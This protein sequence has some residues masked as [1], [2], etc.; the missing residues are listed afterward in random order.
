MALAA[1]WPRAYAPILGRTATWPP[2]RSRAASSAL[3]AGGRVLASSVDPVERQGLLVCAGPPGGS[4][5]A[6]SAAVLQAHAAR[7]RR[8]RRRPCRCARFGEPIAVALLPVAVMHLLL[9][10]PDGSCRLSRRAIVRSATSSA[11]PS[12]PR[13]LGPAAGLPLWPIAIEAVVAVARRRG[14]SQRR[15]VRSAG[16]ERQRMQWFGWAGAVAVEALLVALAL[17]VLL[18][19]PTRA[20]ARGPDGRSAPL[21]RGARHVQHRGASPP[22]STASSP[23]P[24]RSAGLT[25]VVAG[26]LPRSWSLVWAHTP[27]RSERSLLGLSMVS[28]AVA[29]LLYGPARQ[30]LAHVRQPPRL[31]RTRGTR[32][33]PAHLREPPFPRHPDGRAAPA[34][35]GVAEKDAGARQRRGLDGLQ[36]ASRALRLGARLQPDRFELKPDEERR[37]CPGRRDGHGLA[38]ASGCRPSLEGGRSRCSGWHPPRHSGQRARPHRRR[39]SR[40]AG[41]VHDRRRHDADRTGPPGRPGPPQ[42]RAG[43]GP[44]E[45][46][47]GGPRARPT[48]CGLPGAHRGR[49]GRGPPPDRAQPPRRRPAA[50]SGAGGQRPPGPPAGRTRPRGLAARSST[51]SARASRRR[52]RSSARWPTASTRPCWS[53]GASPRRCARRPVAPPC[54]TEVE[55]RGS[56]RHSPEVEAA[57]YFCCLEALQNAGKHAGEGAAV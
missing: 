6:L 47:R 49:L 52:S 23:T 38:R 19:W 40:R 34:G 22:A 55:R 11:L 17:R 33:G 4:V 5:A 14:R 43:L 36:R 1:R 27:S 26:R 44:A 10:I 25:G 31:R 51:S 48:S 50:P 21:C 13:P 7:R 18:G 12:V 29:A 3:R 15:Y 45:V 46:A 2:R 28:A 32:R 54:A 35:G 56:H 20:S 37:R 8:E 41:P 39:A 9:G 42:R 16:L 30:R 53:T 57:V 24:S